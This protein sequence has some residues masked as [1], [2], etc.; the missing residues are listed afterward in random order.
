[1]TSLIAGVRSK[2]GAATKAEVSTLVGQV[3]VENYAL[4]HRIVS[5]TKVQAEASRY[6]N[7]TLRPRLGGRFEQVLFSRRL[8]VSTVMDY[9]TRQ[10]ILNDTYHWETRRTTA[11][12]QGLELKY[13]QSH[14]SQFV[15]PTTLEV[16]QIV[17]HS[18]SQAES[19]LNQLRHGASFAALANRDS[20]DAA[21]ARAGGS[22]GFV[23]TGKASGFSPNFYKT[24]DRLR[25]GQYGIAHTRVGYHIV[26]VQ[27]VRP[28]V[29][30]SFAAVRPVIAAQLLTSQKT[31]QFLH[32]ASQIRKAAK[33]KML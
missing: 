4:A 28:G 14:G 17:V 31:S 29:E 20:L 26:E 10:M 6:L 33:V 12:A 7:H 30:A 18:K 15:T 24:M 22:L 11:V 1:V 5:P 23:E 8:T 25:P 21:S 13:Y 16:R 27:A 32:W 2:S 9:L 19:V 3:A